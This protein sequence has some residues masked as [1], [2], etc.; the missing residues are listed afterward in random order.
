MTLEVG[1]K[2]KG[3]DYT[4]VKQTLPHGGT[5]AVQGSIRTV[6][7]TKVLWLCVTFS[8]SQGHIVLLVNFD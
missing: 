7:G 1:S 2:V 8:L 5:L 4:A 6:A 3:R